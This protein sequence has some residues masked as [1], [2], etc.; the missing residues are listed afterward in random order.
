MLFD[1][2]VGGGEQRLQNGESER[3]GGLE[4]EN[5][6]EFGRLYD[7]KI[8]RFVAPENATGI[9]ADLMIIKRTNMHDRLE[10]AVSYDLAKGYY[11]GIH[12]ELRT[13]VVALSLAVLRKRVEERLIGED[14]DIKLVLDATAERERNR[15][16][17][18]DR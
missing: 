5:Q 1:H 7:R 11:I 17:A 8:G 4:I 3:F 9:D 12:P 18:G 2:L 13:P 6:L 16:R 10:I 14:I 15:R